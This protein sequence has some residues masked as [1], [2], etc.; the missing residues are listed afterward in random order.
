[1]MVFIFCI[2]FEFCLRFLIFILFD[3]YSYCTVL[4]CT[5]LFC[6]VLYSTYG[7]ELE[8]TPTANVRRGFAFWFVQYGIMNSTVRTVVRK[9]LP[10]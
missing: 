5:V 6:T 3:E 4:Y 8:L 9:L 7:S 10:K 2:L 1:M